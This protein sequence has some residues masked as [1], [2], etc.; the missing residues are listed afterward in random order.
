MKKIV[1]TFLIVFA[2]V[3]VVAVVGCAPEEEVGEQPEIEQPARI[4]GP[5]PLITHVIEGKEN[6]MDCHAAT[7]E[8]DW[9]PAGTK[10]LQCH[11]PEHFPEN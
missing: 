3:A 4:A 8:L 5:P 1:L 9:H 6:C 2:V 11:I 10:C 7:I